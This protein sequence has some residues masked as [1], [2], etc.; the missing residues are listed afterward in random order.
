MPARKSNRASEIAAMREAH[1][2][3]PERVA[4]RLRSD[5]AS[6]SRRESERREIIKPTPTAKKSQ[7]ADVFNSL[8]RAV[9]PTATAQKPKKR[10]P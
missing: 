4:K 10:K 5:V 1:K 6:V 3:E 7:V 9:I 2:K 8:K